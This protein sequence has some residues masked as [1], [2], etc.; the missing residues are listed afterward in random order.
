MRKINFYNFFI[1]FVYYTYWAGLLMLLPWLLGLDIYLTPAVYLLILQRLIPLAGMLGVIPISKI[2]QPFFGV[3]G[4]SIS[5][6]VLF[7]LLIITAIAI[8]LYIIN[9][10]LY[11]IRSGKKITLT[12]NLIVLHHLIV[13]LILYTEIV[14]EFTWYGKYFWLYLFFPNS[15]GILLN[16]LIARKIWVL[17]KE[18]IINGGNRNAY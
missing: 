6:F 7:Y 16:I 13:S 12:F 18:H 17:N 4:K 9:R 5:S 1:R 14:V 15:Y 2:V 3:M 11:F 8:Q 10:L